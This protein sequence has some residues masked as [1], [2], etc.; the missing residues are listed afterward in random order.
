MILTKTPFR[1]SFIGGGSDLPSFYNKYRGAVISTS[2]DKFIYLSLHKKF[3]KGYR[4]GYSITENCNT[5]DEINHD[6]ARES[7]RNS[8]IMDDLEITS[9]ADIP[10]GTGLGSSSSYSVGLINA[11]S[12]YKN[13]IFS[14]EE[15]AKS[16]C[17]IEIN[18]LNKSIGK[19]DQYAAAYGGLNLIEFNKNGNTSVIPVTLDY[20]KKTEMMG[21]FLMF[22]TGGVRSANDILTK[23]SYNLEN[24]E[25]HLEL[26]KTLVDLT[27]KLFSQLQANNIEEIGDILDQGWQVKK[28]LSSEISNDY[29]N[30]IYDK[31]IAAGAEGGKLL[32]A[33]SSGFLLF[34]AKKNFHEAIRNSLRLHE[35][36]FNTEDQGSQ[37]I[38]SN[39]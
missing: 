33:G 12:A 18:I 37:I 11:L 23:Q 13:I 2:I 22:N 4:I 39:N 34:Y 1:I 16:A 14:Q 27:Y 32:G 35:V 19:Q 25:T 31:A 15:L 7:I 21:R 38:Y 5:L 36:K 17:N 26:T 20:D 6:I 8:E 10:S 24:S 3:D 9:I 28:K 29:I 30:K